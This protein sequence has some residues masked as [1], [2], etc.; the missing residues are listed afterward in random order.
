MRG[1][2][3]KPVADKKFRGNPG[4]RPL[5]ED[6][7]KPESNAPPCPQWLVGEERE[8]WDYLVSELGKMHT[9]ASSDRSVMVADCVRWGIVVEAKRQLDKLREKAK[10]SGKEASLF[11]MSNAKRKVY[12]D[13]TIEE[14]TGSP[15]KHPLINI[16]NE[17][18]D[19]LE[20]TCSRLGLSP[21]D[22]SRIKVTS[23]KEKPK[24]EWEGFGT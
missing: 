4:H 22:R 16:L 3:P 23:E 11:Y 12:P 8:E 5:N 24:S 15:Q 1:R 19:R 18:M 7:P 9:L 13:G 2:F 14:S 20:A 17:V 10:E 21:S 6:E